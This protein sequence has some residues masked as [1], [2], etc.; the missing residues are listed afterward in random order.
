M[1]GTDYVELQG[2]AHSTDHLGFTASY[3][4]L[5]AFPRV[6]FQYS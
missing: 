1:P 3:A 2:T 6:F 5:D 4:A